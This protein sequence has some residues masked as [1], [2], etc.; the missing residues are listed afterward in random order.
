MRTVQIIKGCEEGRLSRAIAGLLSN[1]YKITFERMRDSVVRA[2]VRNGD[3]RDY[4]VALADEYVFCDCPDSF[5]AGNIC[6]HIVMVAMGFTA[7]QVVQENKKIA[8]K[9]VL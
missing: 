3:S 8:S 7:A 4:H 9:E 2:T 1:S 5:K 6:K